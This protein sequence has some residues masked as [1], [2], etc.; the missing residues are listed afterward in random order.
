MPLTQMVV[1]LLSLSKGFH[2]FSIHPLHAALD[3]VI[4]T[5]RWCSYKYHE[6]LPNILED[7]PKDDIEH[8][9]MSFAQQYSRA[10][11]HEPSPIEALE[12]EQERETSPEKWL[13]SME[14]RE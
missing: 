3:S 14:K 11:D 5:D 12:S 4:L 7:D 1:F 13:E 6:H 10:E 8:Q 2:S 9:M